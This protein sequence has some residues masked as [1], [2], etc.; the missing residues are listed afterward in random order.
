MKLETTRTLA[1]FEHRLSHIKM[2]LKPVLAVPGSAA[3]V[4]CSPQLSWFDR[5]Q[6]KDLGLPKPVSDLLSKLENGD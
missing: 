4:K 5:E 6:Q 3:Q 1:V 2:T